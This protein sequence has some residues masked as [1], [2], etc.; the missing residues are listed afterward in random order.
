M[1]EPQ[2]VAKTMEKFV[3]FSIGNLKFKDSLQ[4]LNSSL[5]KIV[6]NLT[7]KSNA[8]NHL[9]ECFLERWGHLPEE[10][11]QMLTRKGVYPYNYMDG[12][13]KFEETT[14]PSKECFFS[15]LTKAHIS[16]DDFQ[17]IHTLW[18]TY[19]LKNM[20][21]LHDLYMETDVHIWVFWYF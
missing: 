13:N 16:N 1:K 21:E 6:K 11:F 12:W 10:A 15:D 14:L 17:F 19:G 7:A 3:T 4:F 9:R 20:G 2:V 8:F 5:D 18:N